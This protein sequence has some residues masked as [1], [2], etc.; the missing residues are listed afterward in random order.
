VPEDDE[1]EPDSRRPGRGRGLTALFAL[2]ISGLVLYLAWMLLWERSHPAGAAAR[3]IQKGD[4]AARLRAIADLERLGPEDPEVAFPALI[5]GL[6]DPDAAVRAAAA[7]ALVTVIQGE[8]VSGADLEHVGAAVAALLR[9]MNDPQAAVRAAASQAVWMIVMLWQGSPR[10]IDLDEIA[11]AQG[12]AAGDPDVEVRLAGV[13]GLGVVGQRLS[14][15]PPPGLVAA[16]EDESEAVRDA[17]AQGLA[18]FQRGMIRLFPAL[19]KSLESARPAFRPAYIRALNHVR[20]SK[21]PKELAKAMLPALVSALGS[22]DREVRCLALSSIGGFGLE[23]REVIPAL[24]AVLDEPDEGAPTGAQTGLSANDPV[25]AAASALARVAGGRGPSGEPGRAPPPPGVVAP[26]LRL[27]QS[28]M[29]GRRLAAVSALQTFE[30]DDNLIAALIALSRDRDESVRAA[31]LRGL[32]AR[33]PRLRSRSLEA[34]RDALED[35][36]PEVRDAAAS[37]LR[38]ETG[39][40]PMVPALLRHA[41]HDPDRSVRDTCA[42]ALGGF[43]PPNVTAAV[44]PM[45]IEA[46]DRPGASALLRA[47]LIDVLT[48]FGPEA[49]GAVP[50]IARALRSAERDAGRAAHPRKPVMGVVPRSVEELEAE[51]DVREGIDLRENAAR[52]LGRLAPGTPSAGDAVSALAAAVDD[53][54]EQVKLQAIE[55]LAAFDRAARSAAPALARALRQARDR[56]DHWGAGRVAAVLGRIDPTA[57]EAGEAVAFLVEALHSEEFAPRVFAERALGPFGPAAAPAVPRLVA[58]ARQPTLRTHEE[59]G[60]VAAALGQIA[61]GTP[62]EG[63]ALAALVELLQSEPELQRVDTVIDALARFGPR[64]AVALPRLREIERSGDPRIRDAARK[65]VAALEGSVP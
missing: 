44:V 33:A 23:A 65:A 52:A 36:S 53:P 46:I 62:E 11:A 26:L 29:A 55:A 63:R 61:P 14:E 64:A 27:L 51:S 3:A 56:K 59:L 17:A 22:R 35:G 47:N 13:R 2:A 10:I 8:S 42:Y 9:R 41:D 58:L 6:D 34:I 21:Y 38:F 37:A 43:V 18:P 19:V 49:R 7:A 20:P 45:Y 57:P 12:E 50:A 31:A 32:P 28:P 24:L 16:L 25:A 15:D 4:T 60:F 1:A 39:I 54:A 5:V 30:P 48:R 40:E